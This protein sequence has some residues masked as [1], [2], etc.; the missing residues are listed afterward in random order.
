MSVYQ[1]CVCYSFNRDY[2]LLLLL[3]VCWCNKSEVWPVLCKSIKMKKQQLEVDPVD[4]SF[5]F[6]LFTALH[7][8]IMIMNDVTRGTFFS[9]YAELLTDTFHL[10]YPSKSTRSLS[11][12]LLFC[13][14]LCLQ[15]SLSPRFDLALWKE[16]PTCEADHRD[17]NRGTVN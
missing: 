7:L 8:V 14:S 1:I 10:N 4:L 5:F 15:G 13:L 9:Y 3:F 12:S 16:T 17:K 11:L 6:L 2:K